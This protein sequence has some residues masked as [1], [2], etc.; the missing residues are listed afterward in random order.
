MRLV[1]ASIVLF[2]ASWSLADTKA[3]TTAPSRVSAVTV[4]QGSALVTREVSVPQGTGLMELVV[5]PLPPQTIDSTLYSE[6]GDG[7]RVLTTR[8]RTRAVKE[9]TRQEVRAKEDQIHRLVADAERMQKEIAVIEQNLAMVGKLENFTGATMQQLAEKGLLSAETTIALSKY[10]MDTRAEKSAAEV[11]LQQQLKAN[12]E[13]QQFAKRQLQELAA[14]S[15]RTE[16]DAVIVVDKA[17]A[18]AGTI[19]L[20]YLV[21]AASWRPQYKLRA[22][23]EKDP[24]QVEY[25]AGIVQQSGEDWSNVNVVLSTAEPML[26]AAP[27]ELSVLD[28]TVGRAVAAS[29]G[30]PGAAPMALTVGPQGRAQAQQFRDSASKSLIANDYLQASLGYNCAAALE[31]TDE[32]LSSAPAGGASGGAA[33]NHNREGPSVTY[34]LKQKF[35]IP[36]RN[37]EQLIEV[38][39]LELSPQFFYKA[40]PVLTPHVYRLANLTN[41]SDHVLLSGEATMYL[42]TDFVGRMNLP[43]VAIGEK[44]TAGFGVDPQLQVTRELLSKNRSLQGG[45]QVHEFKYRIRVASFKSAPATI[46]VW[47]RLPRAEAEAIGITLLETTPPLS[48]D[49]TYLRVDRPENLLR[50][51]LSIEPNTNG[52][53]AATIDYQFKLEYDRNVALGNFKAG[54]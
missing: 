45:N 51:D 25:L 36:S 10:V 30:P 15:S 18:A 22:N 29:G 27:P 14:G 17:N 40:V 8:Y 6:G 42:G 11:Q 20:N 21:S 9:D 39:R 47:D 49:P 24:V 26:S 4:Y 19:R 3:P 54:K 48:A 35:T 43:L 32:L 7:L 34:H 28:V 33:A 38:A 31:Q 44:F 12:S 53:K 13:A 41:N 50:W 52:E 46:Q 1:C 23:T 2:L 5:T 37:D 16:R